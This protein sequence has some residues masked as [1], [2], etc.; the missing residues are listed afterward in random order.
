M[1]SAPGAATRRT[2]DQVTDRTT[3]PV[4]PEGQVVRPCAEST[5]VPGDTAV[6]VATV[7][8]AT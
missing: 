3:H 5:T 6:T 8:P 4:P 7:P 2:H 1:G